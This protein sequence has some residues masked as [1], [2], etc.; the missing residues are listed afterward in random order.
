M[1]G[2]KDIFTKNVLKT[3][4]FT[5][6]NLKGVIDNNYLVVLKRNK[7]SS[8]LLF[9][10]QIMLVKYIRWLKKASI[11]LSKHQQLTTFSNI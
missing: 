1:R 8:E 10:N 11:M 9:T 4:D 2:Y 5:Y 7:D 6:N 3:K